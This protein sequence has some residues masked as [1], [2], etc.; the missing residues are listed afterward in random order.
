[1][2]TRIPG[3]SLT[4]SAVLAVFAMA[5]HPTAGGA[6]FIEF[7]KSVERLAGLNQAVHGTML[8]LMA[9]T[10]WALIAFAIQRGINRS[11]VLLGL[12][13]W[14]IGFAGM[15]IAGLF[16]GFV[17]VAIARRALAAPTS[18]EQLRVTLQAM[19]AAVAVVAVAGAI[20]MSAA[21]ACWS[22]DLTRDEGPARW[23]G[24]SGLAAGTLAALA[25][26]TG[27]V[28]LDVGGMLTVLAVWAAWFVAVGSLMIFRKV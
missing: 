21:M 25:L 8:A 12:V 9:V 1:M 5:H 28:T 16:N 15:A 3:I 23:V 19:N 26:L 4:A 7:A 11:L 17:I 10:T 2:D 13:A 14:V 6:D 24:L 20:G 18:S 22:A 27:I